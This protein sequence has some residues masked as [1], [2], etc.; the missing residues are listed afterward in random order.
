MLATSKCEA[1]LRTSGQISSRPTLLLP[2]MQMNGD[3]VIASSPATAVAR[4]LLEIDAVLF[5]PHAPVTFKSGIISPVYVD[6][7]RLPFWPSQWRIVIRA[8]EQAISSLMGRPDVVA[9][10]ESAGIPHSAALGYALQLPSVFVRKQ[11][12]D[13]GTKS[14]IE[15][16]SVAGKRVVL[17]EDLITTGGSSLAGIEALRAES[18]TADTCLGIVSYGLAEAHE[19]FREAGVQLETLTTFPDIVREAEAS[20]RFQSGDKALIE[21]W[22]HNPREWRK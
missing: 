18:A 9:G 4:A 14:R 6:N 11:T 5:V 3:S 10:I 15:G 19:A 22:L 7:R 1:M 20:G 12:K 8:F 16:G 21:S 17:I 13:H 2:D